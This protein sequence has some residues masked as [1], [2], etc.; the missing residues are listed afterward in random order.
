MG[1]LLLLLLLALGLMH[2]FAHASSTGTGHERE[3]S[4]HTH[5]VQPKPT[6]PGEAAPPLSAGYNEHD[7]HGTEDATELGLCAAVIGCGA[8]LAVGSR[9]LPGRRTALFLLLRSRMRT[10]WCRLSAPGPAH[11]RGVSNAQLA[12]LRI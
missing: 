6:T 12:V 9:R 10:A 8:L 3:T 7:H 4:I 11:V 2:L 5:V 1:R